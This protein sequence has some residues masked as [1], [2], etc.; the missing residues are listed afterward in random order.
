M[1]L[2]I[3]YSMEQSPSSEADSL[4]VGQEILSFMEPKF[5]CRVHKSLPL[6]PILSQMTPVQTLSL[7]FFN[8]IFIKN[9]NRKKRIYNA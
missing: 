8:I 7:D 4:P 2:K 3:N 6:V 5:H 1:F 9:Y